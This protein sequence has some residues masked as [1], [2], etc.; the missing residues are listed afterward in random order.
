VTAAAGRGDRSAP[1]DRHRQRCYDAEVAAVGGTRA[2]EP[3]AWADLVVLCHRVVTHPWWVALGVPEPVLRAGRADSGR[4]W[5]DGTAVVLAP[6]GRT[7]ITLAHELAHHLVHRSHPHEPAHGAAFRAA[8]VRTATL[9]G[10]RGTGDAL[11]EELVRWGVPPGAW[12][13]PEPPAGPGLAELV[14][15]E[16]RAGGRAAAPASDPTPAPPTRGGPIPLGP[17]PPDPAR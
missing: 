13:G 1:V 8:A 6:A 9:I 3:W 16:R 7:P 5:S 11:A 17:A 4:S 10:G 14:R 12:N 2:D 15:L